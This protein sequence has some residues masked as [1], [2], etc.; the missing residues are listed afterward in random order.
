M[1][2]SLSRVSSKAGD[3]ICISHFFCIGRQVLY[4]QHHQDIKNFKIEL[5]DNDFTVGGG[6]TVAVDKAADLGRERI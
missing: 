4:H 6:C 1:A 5:K 3:Q 2:M